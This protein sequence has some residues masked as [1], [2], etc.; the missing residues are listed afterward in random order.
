VQKCQDPALAEPLKRVAANASSA[1]ALTQQLLALVRRHPMRPQPLDL[2]KV[3]EG[4]L[5]IA[6][7]LLGNSIKVEKS[8]WLNLP[9]VMADPALIEQ[10]L[11]NLI[12]NSRDAMP[13]AGSLTVSTAA[14]RVDEAH[15]RQHEGARP[16]TYVCLS[17]SDTGCGMTPEVQS[18]L[19]EP[20]FTTKGSGKAAGLGLATVHGLVRQHSG[21]IEV[22]SEPG[23]GSQFAVFLPC[24]AVGAA[25]GAR[26][27]TQLVQVV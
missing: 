14:V 8:C 12:L 7:R 17:V 3:L 13:G 9:P 10:I 5:P 26:P 11:H 27:R 20:F 22:N 15:A 2:N 1:G 25:E 4:Q 19:F 23:A 16:G 24:A 6:S 18:R 21:W